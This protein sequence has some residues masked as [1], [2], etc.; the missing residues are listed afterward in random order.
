LSAKQAAVNEPAKGTVVIP[1]AP[2]PGSVHR[3][4][5]L[6][7]IKAAP[8]T[9]ERDVFIAGWGGWFK[10]KPITRA[11]NM[12]INDI[13]GD[14]A[15]PGRGEIWER[16]IVR[17][18]CVEPKISDRDYATILANKGSGAVGELVRAILEASG[19]ARRSSEEAQA[20]FQE[21][22]DEV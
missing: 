7:D 15:K 19:L 5:T 14:L 8:D 11:E 13:A 3:Y 22:G 16:M 4:L 12:K 10:I 18:G 21:S 20:T 1:E 9:A 6:E 2:D 17:Y